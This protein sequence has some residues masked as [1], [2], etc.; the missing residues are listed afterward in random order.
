MDTLVGPRGHPQGPLGHPQ[1]PLGHPQ[2]PLASGVAD[3]FHPSVAEERVA[4]RN[5]ESR[6]RLREPRQCPDVSPLPNYQILAIGLM[7]VLIVLII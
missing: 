5:V 4:I 3:V 2:V 1:V 6:P 7:L